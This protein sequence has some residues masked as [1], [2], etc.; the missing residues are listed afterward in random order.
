MTLLLTQIQNAFVKADAESVAALPATVI[1]A[2]AAY[3]IAIDK[4][5]ATRTVDRR[6]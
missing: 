3:R 2:R 4:V 5:L 6:A 1:Q